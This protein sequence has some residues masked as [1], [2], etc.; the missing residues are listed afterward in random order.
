LLGGKCIDDLDVPAFYPAKILQASAQ[1]FKTSDFSF[2]I[3][4]VPKH[5]DDGNFLCLLRAASQRAGGECGCRTDACNEFTPSHVYLVSL[6]P[7]WRRRT[8]AKGNMPYIGYLTNFRHDEKRPSETIT[9]AP[10]QISSFQRARFTTALH[11]PAT[12]RIPSGW[13]ML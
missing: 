7:H 6:E 2:G 1:R 11:F 9:R 13:K 10:Q 3:F 4:G 5:A 8:Y 12:E